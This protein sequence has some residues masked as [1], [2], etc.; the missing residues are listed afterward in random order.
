V[1]WKKRQATRQRLV[2]AAAL[3]G[4]VI[5]RTNAYGIPNH[6]SIMMDTM[7]RRNRIVYLIL[8]AIFISK[9][10]ISS[11]VVT[12]QARSKEAYLI[13][14]II[15][16]VQMQ[17]KTIALVVKRKVAR[18]RAKFLKNGSKSFLYVIPVNVRA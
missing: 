1:P 2:D 11:R 10:L 3:A 5:R 6:V 7:D 17:V 16:V 18:R 8:A 14:I 12:M 9:R 13:I 15:I 4:I